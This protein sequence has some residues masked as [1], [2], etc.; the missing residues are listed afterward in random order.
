MKTI[1]RISNAMRKHKSTYMIGRLYRK[2]ECT[3]CN[4]AIE[5]ESYLREIHLIKSPYLKMKTFRN[6]HAGERCF[7]IGTGPSLTRDDIKKV[8]NEYTFSCNSMCLLTEELN[9]YPTYYGVQ[10]SGSIHRLKDCIKK[11]KCD[12]VFVAGDYRKEKDNND[13]W[14]YFPR[15]SKYNDYDAYFKHKYKAK[16]SLDPSRMVYDG[17]TIIYTLIQLAVY[18][19][20]TEIFLMG[21]DC[22][23][24]FK[25]DASAH[26]VSSGVKTSKEYNSANYTGKRM[27][28]AYKTAKKYADMKGIRICNATRGGL[29]EVFERVNLDD[30]VG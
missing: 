30:V 8:S 24:G 5:A 13:D 9:W 14:I 12:A 26:I 22:N 18:M 29:L 21:C 16:F 20:F 27:M 25:D 19:G 2:I 4:V 11:L 17:F 28:E 3:V 23:Y 1:E 6:I 15:N 7:I 10:D